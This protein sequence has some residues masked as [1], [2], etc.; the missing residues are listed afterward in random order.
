LVI[1]FPGE[2]NG[3]REISK[4]GVR[5][6]KRN[7]VEGQSGRAINLEDVIALP[8]IQENYPHT[9]CYLLGGERANYSSPRCLKQ[10]VVKNDDELYNWIK[11]LG[12]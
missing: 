12:L 4:Y 8:E 1:Y 11:E 5:Y 7:T 6:Y 2:G 9:I 3:G 10:R